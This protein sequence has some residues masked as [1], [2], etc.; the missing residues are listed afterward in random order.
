MTDSGSIIIDDAGSIVIG[1]YSVATGGNGSICF[2]DAG[3]GAMWVTTDKKIRQWPCPI[4]QRM[5]VRKYND[6]VMDELIKKIQKTP[7]I[8]DFELI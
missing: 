1:P 6:K 7:A 2:G 8:N 4:K 3:A 5:I